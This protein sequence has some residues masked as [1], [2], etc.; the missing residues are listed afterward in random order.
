MDYLEYWSL[1]DKPFDHDASS[2]FYWGAPQREFLAGMHYLAM[3][4]QPIAVLLSPGRCGAT[5]LLSELNQTCGLGD[6]AVEVIWTDGDQLDA[7]TVRVELARSLELSDSANHLEQGIHSAIRASADQ[8][9]KTIWL[10]DRCRLPAAKVARQLAQT[11]EMFS[12]VLVPSE[13]DGRQLARLLDRSQLS[14]TPIF[15]ELEPFDL[16]ETFRYVR[17]SVAVAGGKPD[18]WTDAGIVRLHEMGQGRIAN[19]SPLA[20]AAMLL[21]ARHQMRSVGPEMIEAAQ[22]PIA[23]AA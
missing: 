18:C 22:E 16:P 20:E 14:T 13:I 9:V 15:I 12:A 4:S 1:F 21:A 23:R 6:S 17:Q 10:I 7:A 11:H 5:S 2:R 3:H 19:L 8:R